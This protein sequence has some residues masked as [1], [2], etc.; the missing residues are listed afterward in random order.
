MQSTAPATA[1]KLSDP[2]I[3]AVLINLKIIGKIPPGGRVRRSSASAI[4]LEIET[5][6]RVPGLDSVRRFLTGSGRVQTLALITAVID[7]ACAAAAAMMESKYMVIYEYTAQPTESQV[8]FHD[9]KVQQLR[10]I[11]AE[12]RAARAGIVNL[13]DTTYAD[14]PE[15]S[16]KLELLVTRTDAQVEAILVKINQCHDKYKRK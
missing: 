13:R 16:A 5:P 1:A 14:D 4:V 2:A 10:L 12:L 6:S 11:A 7:R 15:T 8:L 3:D 9:E